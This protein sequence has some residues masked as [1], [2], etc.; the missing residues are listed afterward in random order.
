MARRVRSNRVNDQFDEIITTA[1]RNRPRSKLKYVWPECL[2]WIGVSGFAAVA[3][4]MLVH[5]N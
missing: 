5:Y 1:L 3:V 2:L 4:A